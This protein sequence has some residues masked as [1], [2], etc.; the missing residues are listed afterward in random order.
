ML[1]II[2]TPI[3]NLG[4]ITV[5]AIEVLKSV[6]LIACEDTRTSGKLLAHYGITTQRTSYHEH[7]ERA[8]SAQLVERLLQ[9]ESIALISDAGM[10]SVSDPG[11]RLVR[12]AIEND[13]PLTV[14]PGASSFVT[15]IVG[16]GMPTDKFVFE[17]FLPAKKGRSSRLD[18]IADR[19]ETTILFESPHRLIK[20]LEQLKERCGADREVAVARELT[21]KFEEYIRGG[22]DFVVSEL[23]SRPSIKGEIVLVLAGK[24]EPRRKKNKY[25]RQED[26]N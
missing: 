2:P 18:Q 16:S 26:S 13:I 12:A 17:G 11:Y 20:T 21:K 19:Q 6:D 8:R 5:R 14:L 7:N 4:D 3:G 23:K 1:Y 10:P 15:A 22:L 9:G 24:V 25:P